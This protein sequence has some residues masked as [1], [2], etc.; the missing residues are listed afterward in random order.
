MEDEKIVAL[1]FARDEA[2]I[3]KTQEKYD[4]YCRAIAQRIVLSRED[5]EECVNDTWR[6]AWDTIPPNKPTVLSSYLG[7]LTRR[8][9][10]NRARDNHAQKRGGGQLPLILDELA[11]CI[12]DTEGERAQNEVLRDALDHFLASLPQR[13]RM[14]FMRR[15]WYTD[16]P[17]SIAKEYGMRESSVYTILSRTRKQLKRFLEENEIDL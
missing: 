17:Q 13:T 6:R 2:A 16:T 14:I 4:A 9:A 8:I 3:A 1:F 7:L 12:P 11:E 10:L 5:A 15:Y